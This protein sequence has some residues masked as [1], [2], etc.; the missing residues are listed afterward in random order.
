MFSQICIIGSGPAGSVLAVSLAEKGHEVLVIEAGSSAPDFTLE[1]VTD[2]ISVSGETDIKFGFSRQIGGATNLWAGRIAPLETCDFEKGWPVSRDE[3]ELYYTQAS[4]ILGIKDV[5]NFS[6]DEP[7]SGAFSGLKSVTLKPFLWAKSPFNAGQY[8]TLATQKYKNL[9]ILTNRRAAKINCDNKKIISIELIDTCEKHQGVPRETVSADL[10]ILA[11]GG[12]ETPRILLNSDLGGSAVGRY[13][14]THPKAD[15]AVLKL[16]KRTSTQDPLFTDMPLGAG[17]QRKGLGFPETIQKEHD[18]LNH[19][20]QL[21]PLVEFK[22]TRLFEKVKGSS[23]FKSKFIDSSSLMKGLLPAIGLIVFEAISKLAGLQRKTTIFMLR[24]FL[25]QYPNHENQLTLS[26]K[27]DS[28][29]LPLI[30]IDW[31]F[32]EKD[33]ASVIRFFDLLDKSLKQN[34]IGHI[35]YSEMRNMQDW[36]LIGIHSHFM[37]TTRMGND[38]QTSVTDKNAKLHEVENLYISGPSLFS[39]YGYANPV[40]T[41]VALAL[42]LADHISEKLGQKP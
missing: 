19:Y 23:L 28:F 42:R 30:N 18:L 6:E 15:M 27:K 3:M 8:L 29:G 2:R 36:P 16:N 32:T 38:P 14:S 4:E 37:G 39:T 10:F 17:T 35:E 26:D 11:A 13:F 22:A 41:I 5:G 20:V 33:K 1:A 24:G 34:N 7:C 31:T 40:Y 9:Q 12:I 21:S 25:D